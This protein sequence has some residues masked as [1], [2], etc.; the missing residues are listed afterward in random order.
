LSSSEVAVARGY[1]VFQAQQ[2][3]RLIVMNAETQ[4]LRRSTELSPRMLI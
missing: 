1:R 2:K 3:T 4:R